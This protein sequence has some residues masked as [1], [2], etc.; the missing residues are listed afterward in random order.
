ME[1][2]C[3]ASAP[4]VDES[5]RAR[6]PMEWW[7]VQG[8]FEGPGIEPREFMISLF[9]HALEWGGLSAGSTCSLM[10]S[11][12]DPESGITLARSRVEPATTD[13]L[14][15]AVKIAPPKGLDQ[16]AMKAVTD[17]I[18]RYGPPS[19]IEVAPKKPRI[20]SRPLR[21]SWMDFDFRQEPDGF[22]LDFEE[23]DTGRK[24][25]FR[26]TPSHGR[27][28]LPEVMVPGGNTMDY[29]SY[30]RLSL[31][32]EVD[33]K[34]VSG[35]AW[36]DHQWGSHGWFI[37]GPKEERI[38]GWDWFGVQLDD[39]SDWLIIRHRDQR[40]GKTLGQQA[41]EVDERGHHKIYREFQMDARA[42]W[43]STRT[44][45][46][47]PVRWRIEVPE[48]DTEFDFEP[49]ANDQE[50][51][52]LPPIRA[53]WEGAGRVAGK[54]RGNPVSGAA[55]MELHGYAY[56]LD[57]EEYLERLIGRIHARIE[58]FL[59]RE[60]TEAVLEKWAGTPRGRYDTGAQSAMVSRPLWD[61]IDRG[62]KHW[63]PI[64]GILLLD[65]MG[66]EPTPYES[67]I[68][69]TTEILH[70][71]AL[72]IDDIQ[73]NAQSR[74]GEE[75]IHLRYGTD[76]AIH[77]AN[78]AYFMPLVLLRDYPGLN[79]QQK[80]DLY[81]VLSRLY[82]GAH[83]GQGQDIYWSKT[84]DA[85]R[86]E[87]MVATDIEAKL[88]LLY[89]QKTASVVEA[90]AEGAAI[91][92][93]ASAPLRAAC[94]DFGRTLGIA[95]QIVNDVV[96]FSDSRIEAGSAGLDLRD[97]KVTYLI[98]RALQRLSGAAKKRLEEILC[99]PEL[100]NNDAALAE[101]IA[102]VRRSGAME[103][104]KKEAARMVEKEWEC[105]SKLLPPSE[106]KQMLRVLWTFLLN[107]SDDNRFAE[108]A[109]GN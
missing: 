34:P 99:S 40:T 95:F 77:A 60:F 68:T 76:V 43:T 94:A 45:A 56:V 20:Q 38:F 72:I 35:L 71:A 55:R 29:V 73:D 108:Y 85:T 24:F 59:P 4:M 36:F 39:G 7:F 48:A 96:D 6:E 54:S 22:A 78:T 37:G 21:V 105:L 49:Y 19:H 15:K 14:V 52:V 46:A 107:H 18:D 51:R 92:A 69:V 84:L 11:V 89:T 67:L 82:M 62:G 2:E 47:Y 65:A 75:C 101:G 30:P 90:A 66:V 80:L 31:A 64:F 42:W 83:F 1:L 9:R 86:L 103:T 100:R 5:S 91:I 88:V 81:R 63:R 41:V 57:I 53:V 61:L 106:A 10:V 74:R 33:G 17:E 28:H 23:P 79:D 70:D 109:P 13:F 32:G 8:R 93:G 27:I 98:L 104:C 58:E 3:P 25:S 12:L 97:G 87:K 50:I 44:Q 102:L 26:L 16:R